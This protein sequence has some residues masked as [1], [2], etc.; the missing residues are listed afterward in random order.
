MTKLTRHCAICKEVMTADE[1]FIW[2]RGTRSVVGGKIGGSYTLKEVPRF[3]PKHAFDCFAVKV[4]EDSRA[5][6]IAEIDAACAMA[7]KYGETSEWIENY[8]AKLMSE[9]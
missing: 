7:A 5:R 3:Q 6:A 8:R 2:H 4:A 9:V 1:P